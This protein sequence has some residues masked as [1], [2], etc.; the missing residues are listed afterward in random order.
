LADQPEITPSERVRAWFGERKVLLL[1]DNLEQLAGGTAV[2]GELLASCPGLVLLVTSREPLHL[3]GEQQYEV[4]VLE[5]VEAIELFTVRARAIAP[6]LSVDPEIA[7]AVCE[8]VDRLPLAIELAA[9]RT[10]TLPPAHVLARLE[11]R[12]PVLGTGP[13]D[14]PHRQRTLKATIDWSYDLLTEEE[15]HVFSRLAVFAGGWTFPAAEAVCDADLDMLQALADR[16]M[17]RVDDG[18]YSML[19]TLREYAL[20]RLDEAG[21]ADDVRLRYAHWYV[22]LLQPKTNWYTPQSTL[23]AN[24]SAAEL[25]NFRSALEWAA[26]LGDS[27]TV[28]WL[29]V[30]LSRWVWYRRGQLHEADRWLSFAREHQ[31]DYPLLLQARVLSAARKFVGRRGDHDEAAGLG[32]QALAIYRELGHPEGV[33]ME[34]N[35]RAAS[36]AGRGDLGRA[37]AALE[38]AIDHARTNELPG[39]LPDALNNLG[40]VA[41]AQGDLDEARALCEEGLKLA[42]SA[43]AG[44]DTPNLLINLTH[45]ANLQRRHADAAELGRETL[46]VAI[47]REDSL[48][49]AAAVMQIAWLLAQQGEPERA[50]RLLG[51]GIGFH[52]KTDASL[53]RSDQVCADRTRDRL[54]DQLDAERLQAL[55]DQGRDLPLEQAVRD[56]LSESS[57]RTSR[58]QTA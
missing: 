51:A 16:S 37:R 21:D 4:P 56:A 7:G 1:L 14:A 15:Q 54:C 49:A 55:L 23:P 8:R 34:L 41:I 10:K 11:Q 17:I 48:T 12:L 33:C 44:V 36:A 32:E 5:L 58:R 20:E 28:A 29:V 52:Q 22:E 38:E 31:S 50:A 35:G 9:A 6:H 25:E 42:G 2:L 40:D 39:F 3:A 26:E 46:T 24:Q 18:R 43:G 27:E 57:V 53:Q 19:Q 47:D 30:S 45:I 13:R